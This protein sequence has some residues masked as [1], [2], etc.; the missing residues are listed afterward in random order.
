MTNTTGF[1]VDDYN[2]RV[3]QGKLRIK[4]EMGWNIAIPYRRAPA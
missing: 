1:H 4:F 3:D 2:L